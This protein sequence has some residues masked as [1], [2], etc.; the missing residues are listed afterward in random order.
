MTCNRFY[1]SSINYSNSIVV[2]GLCENKNEVSNIISEFNY[3]NQETIQELVSIPQTS[4][5][6]EEINSINIVAKILNVKV[7]KTP[8]SKEVL[9][10]GNIILSENLE[11]KIVTGRKIIIEGVLCQ[12]IDYTTSDLY[13]SLRSM[14]IYNPFSSYIVVPKEIDINGQIIDSLSINF[15][16]NACIED[17]DMIILDCR[18][19]LKTIAILFYA[20]PNI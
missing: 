17:L 3:W 4:P 20:V 2:T 18:S 19:I 8:R 11:G 1:S 13:D 16:V 15:D 7:I 9:N 6:I 12:M 10:S 5:N 14:T